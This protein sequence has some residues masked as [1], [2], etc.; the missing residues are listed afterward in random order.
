[1]KWDQ[2]SHYDAGRPRRGLEGRPRQHGELPYR[3]HVAERRGHSEDLLE[4]RAGE[5]GLADRGSACPEH[6]ASVH[7]EVVDF[8]PQG[9]ERTLRVGPY[10]RSGEGDIQWISGLSGIASGKGVE[11][12]DLP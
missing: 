4:S 3:R 11:T 12:R 1:M 5:G 9:G 2:R 7:L 8:V 10:R 6:L